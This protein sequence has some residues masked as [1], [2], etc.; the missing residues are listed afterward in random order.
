MIMTFEEAFN[1]LPT[2]VNELTQ[3]L[4]LNDFKG[5][6]EDAAVCP[7]AIYFYSA[8]HKTVYVYPE[9]VLNVTDG[10]ER[11]ATEAMVHF[12]EL[13]DTGDLPEL[14]FTLEGEL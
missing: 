10:E 4:I 9:S 1:A 6:R 3:F 14:D 11:P 5:Q 8:T 12:I 7:L 13:F 2:D